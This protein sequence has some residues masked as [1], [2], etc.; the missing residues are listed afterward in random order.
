VIVYLT[1]VG[2]IFTAFGLPWAIA[3]AL[4]MLFIG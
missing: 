3:A 4:L 1:V 2:V